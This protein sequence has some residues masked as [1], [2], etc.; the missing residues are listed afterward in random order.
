LGRQAKHLAED[1]GF[2]F[3]WLSNG[4]GFCAESWNPTGELFDGDRFYPEKI[5]DVK[6]KIFGFWKLFREECPSLPIRTRGTNFSAG[7]DFASDAVPLYDIYNSN[8]NIMPPPNS[9][10][11]ALDGN[12]GIELMGHMTRICELPGEE[13]MFRY[14]I[15]D[16]W[17]VNTPWYDRYEGQPH[18]IYLPMALSRIDSDGKVRSAGIFN[19]LSIDNTFGNMPDSCVNEPLPHILKA[20]KN[21]PDAPAPIIW[22]YPLREYTTTKNAKKLNEMMSGDWF[23]SAAINNGFPLSGVVSCDNF[24]KTNKSIYKKSILFTPVPDSGSDFEKEILSYARLGG[25]V[26]FYGSVSNASKEFLDMFSLE[27]TEPET[28]VLKTC[29]R[30]SPDIHTDGK[31]PEKIN[32][33]PLYSN[34]GIDTKGS[35]ITVSDKTISAKY[36]NASW[37][38]ATVSAGKPQGGRHLAV[39]DKNEFMLSEI[40]L[41]SILADYGYSIKF[42]KPTSDVKTPVIMLHRNDNAMMFSVYSANT[43]VET[44]LKFPLGAPILLGYETQ[45]L[46]GASSYRFPRADHRECRIF[47]EQDSGIV[48]AKEIPPVNYLYRRKIQLTGLK[49]ATVRFFG[50]EYCKE[51]IYAMLNVENPWDTSDEFEWELIKSPEYGTYFEAKNVTGDMMFFMPITH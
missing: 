18:D 48:G 32:V 22:V 4:V 51:N 30:Y 24:L 41:R 33:R 12:F 11:A 49:N 31:T 35:G 15:H 14:Y 43:T 8:L 16:P 21:A 42:K 28:G 3:L 10:W 27:L 23:V 13:F 1:L 9:P 39:D 26:I 46:D 29:A 5:E 6:D 7:I 17:W 34:G 36:K 38:R 44:L 47:V 20:E 50:E 40:L 25:K 2:D 45:I 19:I 37:Y